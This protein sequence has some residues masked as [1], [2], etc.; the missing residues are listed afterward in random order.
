MSRGHPTVV[1]VQ[2]GV[3]GT[4]STSRGGLTHILL[5]APTIKLT[6]RAIVHLGGGEIVAVFVHEEHLFV[7]RT[8]NLTGL[9]SIM[10]LALKPETGEVF[11]FQPN[12]ILIGPSTA[13]G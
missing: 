10:Q 12:L 6:E 13:E 4:W 8:T 2:K 3:V 1:T 9:R 11:T 5:I 7:R